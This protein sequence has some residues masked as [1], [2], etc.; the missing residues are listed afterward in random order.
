M[1]KNIPLLIIQYIILITL[2]I[3][4]LFPFV[5]T[6]L[7]SIKLDSQISAIPT[8]WFPYPPTTQ[9]FTDVFENTDFVYGIKNS[10]TAGIISTILT[11]LI[12]VP[13]AWGFARHKYRGSQFV[14][15]AIVAVRML[16]N[17][18]L[19]IPFFLIL[20]DLKLLNTV[21]G[22]VIMYLPL[23]LT[24]NVWMLYNSFKQI[25]E[26]LEQAALLDGLNVFGALIR[27]IIPV[28]LP[29]I[30]TAAIFSFLASWN[31]FFF[32]M[33]TTSSSAA[34]T[35]PVYIATS[36]TKFRIFWGR[37]SAMSVLSVI[38][39]ILATLLAQKSLVKGLTAGSLKG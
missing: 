39:A 22:L 17:I 20:R 4:I 11:L 12:G 15:G 2:A 24:L 25:P 30:G 6:F 37:M 8:I 33:L 1:K 13:A 27:I 31:E 16:P 5:W 28:S 19:G 38:P 32:A 9:H 29:A 14:F 3:I 10:L 36:V 35:I 21:A 23:Q 34:M 26:D 18:V 7:T